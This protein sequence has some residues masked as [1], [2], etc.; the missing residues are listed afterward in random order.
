MSII[1]ALGLAKSFADKEVLSNISFAV[2]KGEKV[3]ITGISGRGKTTLLRIIAG[4]V[5]PDKGEI[6][7]DNQEFNWH[8]AKTIRQQIA[9]LPQGVELMTNN[10]R[11]LAE[12]ISA[13]LPPAIALANE[14]NLP[15]NAMNQPF[16]E[17]SGGEKQRLLISLLLS[18]GRPILILDEPTSALDESSTNRLM[19]IIWSQTELTVISTSH[20]AQWNA[21]C[22]KII[23]L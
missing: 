5:A 7:F 2:E 11:E 23:D 9:Y 16:A 19:D 10:G 18:L 12:L 4:I 22:H 6:F 14:L 13:E 21:K 15:P 8:S 20:S 1:R 3:S 17:L